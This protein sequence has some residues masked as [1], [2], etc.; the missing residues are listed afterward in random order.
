MAKKQKKIETDEAEIKRILRSGARLFNSLKAEKR[1]TFKLVTFKPK[2]KGK[3][4]WLAKPFF[5]K[6]LSILTGPAGVGK[7]SLCAN[8]ALSN[9]LK[10]EELWPGGPK[11]DGRDSLFFTGGMIEAGHVFSKLRL[12]KK[13][14]KIIESIQKKINPLNKD[15]YDYNNPDDVNLYTL[16]QLA[17]LYEGPD[18]DKKNKKYLKKNSYKNVLLTL[19]NML[20]MILLHNPAFVFFDLKYILRYELKNITKILNNFMA[21]AKNIHTTIIG[22]ATTSAQLTELKNLPILNIKKTGEDRLLIKKSGFSDLPHGALR[23]KIEHKKD[24]FLADGLKYLENLSNVKSRQASQ[25]DHF[26]EIVAKLTAKGQPVPTAELKS[27]A[28][29]A[30]ISTYFL[31]KPHWP[32]YGLIAKGEG[33][34][35]NYR[36]VLVPIQRH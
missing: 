26:M 19:E 23:F 22:L 7:I 9:Q 33:F 8:L 1:E 27:K 36:Q 16:N 14:V 20:Q 6:G 35:G 29:K 25:A 31:A 21:E 34:G 32:D 28:R 12:S 3:T 2:K 18:Q 30:G 15:D 4:K 10:K 13:K 17:F 24:C 11:G 5:K